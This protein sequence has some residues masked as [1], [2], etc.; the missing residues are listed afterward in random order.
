MV[1]FNEN[2]LPND[3][4]DS[5][6]SD[7]NKEPVVDFD[8]KQLAQDLGVKFNLVLERLEYHPLDE[9][10]ERSTAL[11]QEFLDTIF[12][13]H[14]DIDIEMAEA[15]AKNNLEIM[16]MNESAILGIIEMTLFSVEYDI[17]KGTLDPE[18]IASSKAKLY[19]DLLIKNGLDS[20]DILLAVVNK[21]IPGPELE[22]EDL[23]LAS[24][25][26]QSMEEFANKEERVKLD[27]ELI[28]E[29]CVFLGIDPH[30]NAKQNSAKIVS[31]ANVVFDGRMQ[32]DTHNAAA[33]REERIRTAARDLSLDETITQGIVRF[34]E[35][36][37]PLN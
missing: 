21:S 17:A 20:Q 18:K 37:Y 25:F 7:L 35:L 23:A 29:A 11:Q 8:S 10:N 33:N 31:I 9:E 26:M 32:F 36:K 12:Q 16:A 3:D 15:L 24:Y 34:I 6:L 13:S 2:F 14:P 5:F 27:R 1:S 28:D 19:T 22:P 4:F 30:D